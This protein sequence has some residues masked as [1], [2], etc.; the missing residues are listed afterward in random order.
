MQA[1]GAHWA[2]PDIAS[3]AAQLRRLA[4]DVDARR[5][6]GARGAMMARARLGSA[7]L[8]AAIRA[9]GL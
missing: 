2:E 3:A 1:R 8:V 7:P 9:V 5:A 6:L 4:D